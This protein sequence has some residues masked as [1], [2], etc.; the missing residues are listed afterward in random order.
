MTRTGI[1]TNVLFRW[2]FHDPSHP[3]QSEAAARAVTGAEGAL[4]ISVVV[5]AELAWLMRSK[6][7]LDRATQARVLKALLGRPEIEIAQRAEVEAAT[8]AFAAGGPGF[9][10]QLLSALNRSARCRTTLTFDKAAARAEGF[11]LID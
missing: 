10:D 9:A 8:A 5:L 4:H 11:T 1:D 7:G 2:L 3:A 6:L